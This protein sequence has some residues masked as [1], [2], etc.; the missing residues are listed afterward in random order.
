M[1]KT[2]PAAPTHACKTP[3]CIIHNCIDVRREKLALVTKISLHQC[4]GVDGK[5]T[6]WIN[7]KA[8]EARICLCRAV[9]R[10]WKYNG[11]GPC[12]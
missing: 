2:H 5:L 1:S 3:V 6:I 9:G 11:K 8:K 10:R 4:R 7:D 12:G